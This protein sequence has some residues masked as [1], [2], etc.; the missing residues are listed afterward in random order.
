MIEWRKSSCSSNASNCVEV[1]I[2]HVVAVRDS[3]NTDGPTI[4]FPRGAWSAFVGR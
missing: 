2:T 3:K 1:S 4:T